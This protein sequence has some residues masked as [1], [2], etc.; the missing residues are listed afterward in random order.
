MILFSKKFDILPQNV[1]YGTYVVQ[2]RL[3]LELIQI[4]KTEHDGA[5]DTC[6][7]EDVF[8]TYEKIDTT[9]G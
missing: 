1:K 5:A 2:Q 3:E 4:R 7:R 9:N 8:R 6:A